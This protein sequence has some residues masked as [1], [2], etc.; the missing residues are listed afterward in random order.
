MNLIGLFT[1]PHSFVVGVILTSFKYL[2]YLLG[3]G[4][5]MHFFG[6]G[7]IFDYFINRFAGI[8][9]YIIGFIVRRGY[10]F[11]IKPLF[12]KIFVRKGVLLKE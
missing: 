9:G 10:R 4:T 5:I 2:G 8:M 11:A 3:I 6:M 1:H 7:K 12:R